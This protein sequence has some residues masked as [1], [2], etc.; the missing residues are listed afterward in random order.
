MSGIFSSIAA[1][2]YA[3]QTHSRSVE[4]AGKN[5]ANINNPDYAR[6]RVLTGTVGTIETTLGPEAGPLV[7]V[8]IQQLRDSFL[9][10]QILN[11]ISFKATLEAQDFRLR[12]ALANLGENLDRINDAQF[13]GDVSV[14]GGGLRG[15]VD[16]FFN[17][18]ESF[19]ARPNDPTTKQILLQA[20]QNMTDSFN[21]IDARFDRLQDNLSQQITDELAG[22]NTRLQELNELNREIARFEVSGISANDLRDLRQAKLEE[23]SKF[24]LVESYDIPGGFGE[25]GLRVRDVNGGVQDLLR[26]GLEPAELIYD[27]SSGQFSLSTSATPLDLQAGMLPGLVSVQNDYVAQIRRDINALANSIATGVNEIYYQGF[28]DSDPANVIAERSFFAQPTPPPSVSGVP[29]TV[30][31]GSLR[32][33]RGPSDPAVTDFIPLNVETLTATRTGFAGANE[34]ALEIAALASSG[35]ADLNGVSFS[36]FASRTVIGLGQEIL[37][38]NNR[39]DVQRNVEGILRE[40]R[41]EVSGVSMDEEVSQMIQFQRAFQA[42]SRVFNVLSEMLEQIVNGLR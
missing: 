40:R 3:L 35:R 26:V 31:A 11:E 33:Y 7:A 32:L 17:A 37:D 30:T 13:V 22:F 14:D 21:R 4:Q 41:A 1:A 12:Q 34:M 28:D 2:S 23:V 20:A 10:R 36:D 9:D 5:I 16:T 8:G 39:L 25:I 27:Q 6:Q 29:G 38:I 15:S 19:S 18:F 42:S 24:V